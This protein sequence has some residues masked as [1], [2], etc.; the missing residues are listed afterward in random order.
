MRMH[1]LPLTSLRDQS[2]PFD[3]LICFASFEGRCLSIPL[4]TDP[5]HLVQSLVCIHDDATSA[6]MIH[7]DRIVNHLGNSATRVPLARRDPARIATELYA[8]V[9]D[10]SRSSRKLRIGLDITTFTHESLLIVL[11]LL[12]SCLDSR[13]TIVLLYANALEYSVGDPPD[14]KWL[15]RGVRDVRSVFGYPGEPLPGAKY[16]LII[17]PGIE[18]ERAEEL[19]RE[20]EPSRISVGI[21]DDGEVDTRPHQAVHIHHCERLRTLAKDVGIFVFP[22]YSV[23]GTRLALIDQIDKHPQENV[24]VA[25]MN[26]KL[27]TVGA[28]LAARMRPAVQLCYVVP[29]LYNYDAY[30]A[31]GTN[32]FICE[33]IEELWSGDRA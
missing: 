6:A 32:C 30:S 12:E 29:L 23:D 24:V 18:S 7:A 25:P 22:A 5:R 4:H 9:C 2:H 3:V 16:H 21:A 26:T 10:I 14:R 1:K 15:S 11:R 27:S 31:P 20:F 17:L 19:A 33:G 8:R 13:M 28:S